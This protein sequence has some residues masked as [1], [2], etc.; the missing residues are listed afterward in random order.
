MLQEAIREAIRA[1][2]RSQRAIARA[3]GLTPIDVSRFL[4][5]KQGLSVAAAE[6]L[7][8]VLGLSVVANGR[9]HAPTPG[10]TVRTPSQSVQEPRPEAS[11]V[12]VVRSTVPPPSAPQRAIQD[13]GRVP[14]WEVSASQPDDSS[15]RLGTVDAHD[16]SGARLRASRTWP[17]VRPAAM[18][19]RRLDT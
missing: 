6:R 10:P 8:S 9:P 18:T 16:L 4:R 13:D 19:Y 14:T 11:E 12:K 5:G 2:G 1:D 3:V 17:N 7:M 15:R